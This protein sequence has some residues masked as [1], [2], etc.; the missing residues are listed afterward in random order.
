MAGLLLVLLDETHTNV[1]KKVVLHPVVLQ[2]Q[3]FA[4]L[5]VVIFVILCV[6]AFL[7]LFFLGPE[8]KPDSEGEGIV[9]VLLEAEAVGAEKVPVGAAAVADKDLVVLL[10]HVLGTSAQAEVV[11][12][13]LVIEPAVVLFLII[14]VTG[15]ELCSAV[16]VVFV[17]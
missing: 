1:G 9:L 12:Y 3:Y 2:L 7:F 6:V 14:L 8:I 10:D 13:V 11:R 17:G 5:I 15:L 16:L 4:D